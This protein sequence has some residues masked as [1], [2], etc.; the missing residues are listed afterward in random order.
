ME[1]FAPYVNHVI[2]DRRDYVKW[3]N[4]AR[5]TRRCSYTMPITNYPRRASALGALSPETKISKKS[6]T[7]GGLRTGK[8]SRRFNTLFF[9]QFYFM[10]HEMSPRLKCRRIGMSTCRLKSQGAASAEGRLYYYRRSKFGSRLDDSISLDCWFAATEPDA[11]QQGRILFGTN[12]GNNKI[13]SVKKSYYKKPSR[14]KC[15]Q[16]T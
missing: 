9:L 8:K 15:N 5:V 16:G 7:M 13:I 14:V 1:K 6:H 2:Y 10:S 3:K 4:R 11:S 12:I